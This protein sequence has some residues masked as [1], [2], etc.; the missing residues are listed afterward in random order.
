M[1][2]RWAQEGSVARRSPWSRH[3]AVHPAGVTDTAMRRPHSP[4]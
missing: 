1:D 3:R 4:Q 2:N